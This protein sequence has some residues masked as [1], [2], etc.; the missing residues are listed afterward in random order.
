MKKKKAQFELAIIKGL[1]LALVVIGGFLIYETMQAT[2]P[3]GDIIKC[4]W[5]C[6]NAEWSPCI[7]GYSYRNI[8]LCIPNNPE[9]LNSEP[10][11]TNKA[12]CD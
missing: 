8:D 7:D 10:K 2:T 5:D 3:K 9:C 4:K 6:S 12:Y 1:V 11:P